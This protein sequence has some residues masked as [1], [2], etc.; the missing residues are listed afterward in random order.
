M[1]MQT[2]FESIM[3]Y[4]EI[5][6]LFPTASKYISSCYK[7]EKASCRD[8][9][10]LSISCFLKLVTMVRI[11]NLSSC[12]ISTAISNIKRRKEILSHEEQFLWYHPPTQHLWRHL[13]NRTLTLGTRDEVSIQTSEQAHLPDLSLAVCLASE[14]FFS[15]VPLASEPFC[16]AVDL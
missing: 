6:N 2:Y 9:F 5:E 13:A 8:H 10:I 15:A 4:G 7:H 11:N 3:S 12:C 14:P 16:S 1:L